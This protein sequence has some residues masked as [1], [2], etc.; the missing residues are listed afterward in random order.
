MQTFRGGGVPRGNLRDYLTLTKPRIMTLLLLTGAF[1]PIDE[2]RARLVEWHGEPAYFAPFD[3]DLA[4][5][6]KEPATRTAEMLF[7]LAI[8]DGAH[9]GRGRRRHVETPESIA[10]A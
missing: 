8:E 1:E 9:R 2:A 5:I 10:G 3:G 6:V 4:R 7:A